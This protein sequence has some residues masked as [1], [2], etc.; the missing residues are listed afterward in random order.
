MTDFKHVIAVTI[1]PRANIDEAN[2]KMIENGIRMLL[3]VED[4]DS[5]LGI[6][7]AGDMLGERPMQIVQ[8]RGIRHSDIEVRD[9]VTLHAMLEVMQMRDVL[10][11]RVGHV[12]ATLKRTQ[13]Q[14]ALVVEP[15]DGDACQ[16]VR[17]MFSASQIAR[18]LGV[19][20]HVGNV[21]RTFAEIETL[22]N[23]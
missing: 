17:G 5:V 19:P 21:A 18:Q 4:P 1:E 23:H 15:N 16:A 2:R 7:T 10:N 14:H 20:V 12:V 13:R 22:L 6:V 9:I 3:V 8:E 11:A